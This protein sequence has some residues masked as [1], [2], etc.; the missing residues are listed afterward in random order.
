M[1]IDQDSQMK[2]MLEIHYSRWAL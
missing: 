2:L 1:I